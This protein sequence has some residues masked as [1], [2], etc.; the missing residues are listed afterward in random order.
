MAKTVT[1]S[2]KNL[3]RKLSL[4]EQTQA[5]FAGKKTLTKFAKR[6]KGRD[7]IVS[8]KY[9]LMFKNTVD[10]TK[11]STFTVQDGLS[12]DIGVKDEKAM[13][14]KKG[15]P[16]AKYLYPPIGGGSTEAY[17]TQFTQYLRDRNFMNRGD[18]PFAVLD[19]PL[20][21]TGKGGRVTRATYKNT[22]IALSK[23]QK[24][25]IKSRSKGSKIMDAR[26]I[27]L[28][29]GETKYKGGIYREEPRNDGKFPTFLRP[30]FIFKST[31]TQAP[32]QSFKSIITSESRRLIPEMWLDEIQDLAKGG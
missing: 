15:N 24:K 20:I 5:S 14:S 30:L 28:K 29:A 3:K 11:T 13:G 18:Y 10:F 7:G 9:Q 17:G 19:N 26:V 2:V 22:I 21:R 32:K 23:T 1:F 16:A 25:G 4:Y 8:K 27:A 6:M 31:P 12:L